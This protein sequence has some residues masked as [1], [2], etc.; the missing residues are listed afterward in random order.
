MRHIRYSR[1]RAEAAQSTKTLG[2]PYQS[3]SNGQLMPDQ[4]AGVKAGITKRRNVGA[5][6][7][8]ITRQKRQ[9][10]ELKAEIERLKK[11]KKVTVLS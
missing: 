1:E 7:A 9:I 10:R 2:K 4:T 6:K 8:V 3:G 5:L 11:A